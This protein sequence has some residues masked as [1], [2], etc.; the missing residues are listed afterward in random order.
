[1]LASDRYVDSSKNIVDSLRLV[2]RSRQGSLSSRM[3]WSMTMDFNCRMI[4]GCG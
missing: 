3:V 2:G 1:M 4:V